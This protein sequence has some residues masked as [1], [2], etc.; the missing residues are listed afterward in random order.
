MDQEW[1]NQ[2][3]IPGENNTLQSSDNP[4]PAPGIVST[5]KPIVQPP[6]PQPATPQASPG[7]SA[8]DT[9]AGGQNVYDQ[10]N[11]GAAA[12]RKKIVVLILVLA[13]IAIPGGIGA[14][15]FLGNKQPQKVDNQTPA[16]NSTTPTQP[17]ITTQPVIENKQPAVP[18]SWKMVD[19]KL[20]YSLKVPAD[21]SGGN[22]VPTQSDFDIYKSTTITL[23]S[24]S[25]P[26][27]DIA[28]PSGKYI[29]TGIQS[30]TTSKTEA[31][32]EKATTDSSVV[33][34]A[35]GLDK[36]K[37][38]VTLSKLNISGKQW[39]QVDSEIPDSFSK[40]L[41]L[42]VND[43]AVFITISNSNKNTLDKYSNDYLFPIAASVS[44]K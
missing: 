32:F 29:S 12:S 20:G 33:A 4:Q 30:I 39:T 7:F 34:D 6:A 19:T 9:L 38:K 14:Y 5:V 3:Q 25:S 1:K 16:N 2:N 17:Q 41:Y 10:Y 28:T 23:G 11:P 37:V 26:S 13:L 15:S 22:T 27:G 31:D 43:H 8:P 44:L 24:L 36:S 18:I 35:L 40:T 42:W 21:W